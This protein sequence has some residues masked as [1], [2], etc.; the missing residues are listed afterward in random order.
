MGRACVERA[1]KHIAWRDPQHS[2]KMARARGAQLHRA[3][4]LVL[5]KSEGA[6]VMLWRMFPNKVHALLI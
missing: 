6:R 2:P 5:A 4:H 1:P 3:G